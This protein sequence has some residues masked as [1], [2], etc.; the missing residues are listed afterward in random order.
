MPKKLS[1]LVILTVMSGLAACGAASSDEASSA[2]S[3]GAALSTTGTA[4]S[5]VVGQPVR[6]TLSSASP[7]E[8]VAI[9]VCT[10]CGEM[11]FGPGM[12]PPGGAPGQRREPPA[13]DGTVHGMV[14]GPVESVDSTASTLTVLGGAIVTDASTQLVG[15][16]ALADIPV[17]ALADVRVAVS[18]DG[19]LLAEVV[20]VPQPA[21]AGTITAIADDGS[22]IT[23]LGRTVALTAETTITLVSPPDRAGGRGHGR[24]HGGPGMLGR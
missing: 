18:A 17:G 3:S 13:D 15:V 24:R 4:A 19:S 21:L 6:V 5:L 14:Q 12:L 16:S 11:G 7:A 2:S 23:V 9:V 22:S 1:F 10:G 20:R 8:A